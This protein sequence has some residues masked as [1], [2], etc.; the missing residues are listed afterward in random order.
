MWVDAFERKYEGKGKPFG[1]EEWDQLLGHCMVS[2]LLSLQHRKANTHPHK[3]YPR[4]SWTPP[5]W[6]STASS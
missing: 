1:R 6:P 5:A 2:P 4:L 3:A